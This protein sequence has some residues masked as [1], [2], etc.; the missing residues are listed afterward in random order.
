[1]DLRE[2]TGAGLIDWRAL[3]ETNGDLEEALIL[4][5][6]GLPLPQKKLAEKLVKEL[7]PMLLVLTV[8]KVFL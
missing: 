1:M 7:F 8:K 3:A 5:K 2:K 4:R 6:K